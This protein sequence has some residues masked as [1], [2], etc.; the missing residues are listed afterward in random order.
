MSGELNRSFLGYL[1]INHRVFG[2]IVHLLDIGHDRRVEKLSQAT[3]FKDLME[4]HRYV[5]IIR[6]N[7]EVR[8]Y[9][10]KPGIVELLLTNE[11][12]KKEFIDL[13]KSE[14]RKFVGID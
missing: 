5:Y 7:S 6:N 3:W 9:I 4:D 14:H 8:R 2:V 12:A 1:S 11:P 13:V 10:S